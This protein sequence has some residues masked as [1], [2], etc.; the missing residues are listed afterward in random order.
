MSTLFYNQMKRLLGEFRPPQIESVE[1]APESAPATGL[2]EASYTEGA[3]E[4]TL[5]DIVGELPANHLAR[6]QLAGLRSNLRKRGK[7]DGTGPN[8]DPW[9]Q[10]AKLRGEVASLRHA[11]S[12]SR[13]TRV[14]GRQ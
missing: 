1:T 13:V 6:Q 10:V 12:L 2:I 11:L 5:D 14:S 9:I 7:H 3:Y 8:L 4:K